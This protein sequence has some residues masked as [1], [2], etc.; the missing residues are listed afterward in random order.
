MT[1]W[2]V[3]ATGPSLIQQDVEACRG[4]HVC[5]VNN[6]HELA[7]WADAM[8]ASDLQ[9]WHRHHKSTAAFQGIKYTCKQHRRVPFFDVVEVAHRL[10]SGLT[11]HPPIYTGK[12]SGHAAINL[13]TTLGATD[14]A[15]LGFDFQKTNGLHHYFGSH[16]N[17]L[18]NPSFSRHWFDG[19]K[20]LAEDA[21]KLGIRITNCSRQ[22]AL[23]CFERVTID[24]WLGSNRN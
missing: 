3:I 6:A 13:V 24:E 20:A 5:V 14:I 15:L 8:Y 2:V 12:N 1:S 16:R 22:T 11:I 10:S 19:M 4:E 17:G 9:W 23:T 21:K 7:P 18:L